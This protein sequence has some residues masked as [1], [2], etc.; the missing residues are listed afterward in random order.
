LRGTRIA[1]N[2]DVRVIRF[3]F[4][5]SFML[6]LAAAGAQGAGLSGSETRFVYVDQHGKVQSAEVI[7]RYSGKLK[8]PFPHLDPK[9]ARAATIAEERAHAHSRRSCWRYVKEALLAAGAVDSYPQ[10]ALA[11]QAGEELVNRYGFTRL[12]TRDPYQAPVGSVLV[13]GSG[14]GP[15]HVEIRTDHGFVSDFRTPTP[16]HRPLIGIYAKVTS[17]SNRG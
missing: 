2:K 15:G 3:L 17:P 4:L 14:R 11:R 13:Y 16:S 6:V 8:N 1:F 9:L 10:T 5:L 7:S 12:P